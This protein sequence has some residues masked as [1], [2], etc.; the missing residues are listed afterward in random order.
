M[1]LRRA[2]ALSGAMVVSMVGLVRGFTS[3]YHPR[4][5]FTEG[6]GGDFWRMRTRR[7]LSI[8]QGSRRSHAVIGAQGPM[9]SLLRCTSLAWLWVALVCVIDVRLFVGY[10]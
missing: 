6:G 10:C 3:V 9:F 1:D 8:V 2:G 7:Y 4:G 5:G